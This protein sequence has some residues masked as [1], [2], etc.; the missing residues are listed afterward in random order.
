MIMKRYSSPLLI[1]LGTALLLGAVG[2]RAQVAEVT[3]PD[4]TYVAVGSNLVMYDQLAGAYYPQ[5][6]VSEGPQESPEIRIMNRILSTTL[7]AVEAPDV[8]EELVDTE[9]ANTFSA[10]F[11]REGRV[12][13]RDVP[14]NYFRYPGSGPSSVS[15]FYMNGYGYLFT[16]RWSLRSGGIGL[17]SDGGNLVLQLQ[18]Q[19]R[20]LEDLI[21]RRQDSRAAAG[22]SGRTETVPDE[23]TEQRVEATLQERRQRSEHLSELFAQ[24]RREYENR[25]L[26]ALVTALATYGHTLHQAADDEVITILFEQ[27]D[28]E[29]HNLTLT[30]ERD[31]LGGPGEIERARQAVQVSRG[32]N[33]MS[34]ALRTQVQIMNE[35]IAESFR[36]FTSRREGEAAE[37]YDM[38]AQT[39]VIGGGSSWSVYGGGSRARYLPGYGVIFNRSARMSSVVM[40]ETD[41]AVPEPDLPT[42]ERRTARPLRT[43][44]DD[45]EASRARLEEHLEALM[46]KTAE[47]LATYGTTLTELDDDEWVG[48]NY[49]VGSGAALLQSGVSRFLVQARIS[50]VRQAAGQADAPEWLYNRLVTNKKP[51]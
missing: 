3:T 21:A 28:D 34:E 14:V 33:D 49:D 37:A 46:H 19:N 36:G 44:L 32:T 20:Q 29:E 25:I 17:V 42:S 24:W 51:E 2:A 13:E 1:G 39:Y 48:I 23:E 31:R 40:M 6:G 12:L 43:V 9:G 50:D 30:V 38:L 22:R 15:G 18:E 10:Y 35:I 45:P 16:I 7:S 26:D 41:V 27:G 8:P 5:I 47:I 11:L 4:E